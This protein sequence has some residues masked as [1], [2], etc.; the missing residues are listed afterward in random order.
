MISI[1]IM[2]FFYVFDDDSID[3]VKPDGI[4]LLTFVM[5]EL[6]PSAFRILHSRST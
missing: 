4:C 5:N 6:H 1:C 3:I 2:L